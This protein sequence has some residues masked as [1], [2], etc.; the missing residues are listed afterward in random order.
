LKEE[1]K[2]K[3]QTIMRRKRVNKKIKENEQLIHT[4]IIENMKKG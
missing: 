2:K 3:N 1:K 4:F